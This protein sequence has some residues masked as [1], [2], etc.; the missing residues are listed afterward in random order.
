MRNQA[1]DVL[2]GVAIL[3]VLGFHYSYFRLWHQVGW[4]GVD[5]FFVLSGFLIS[6]LLFDEYAKTGTI[7]LRRFW[8][9]RGF[10]IYPPY[11]LLMF[12]TAVTFL[13]TK[14]HLPAGML[15]GLLFMQSYLPHVW[16]HT[17]SL[18]VE[19][20]FYF[21]LP[22]LLVLLA[23]RKQMR[24]VVWIFPVIALACLT[25]RYVDFKE[26]VS[27]VAIHSETHLR[28][29]ALFFGVFIRWWKTFERESFERAARMPLWIGAALM[30]PAFFFSP[31]G[32]FMDTLGL[33]LLYVA[34]GMVLVW[35]V[36]R[37]ASRNPGAR[38]L[39]WIGRYSY[40][41]YLW[42][43]PL[44]AFLYAGTIDFA[45]FAKGVVVSI[46][47]GCVMAKVV[48]IPG[49]KIRDKFFPAAS[50]RTAVILPEQPSLTPVAVSE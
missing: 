1:L 25:L 20:H 40:S 4:A 2:R 50:R 13:M 22:L 12:F 29:D 47:F 42:H 3:L 44:W 18:S 46:L 17:W 15:A 41:I 5:L 16:Q 10:K 9:R 36:E 37:P 6:G 34:F 48:E 27:A 14:G 8:I 26:G 7:D 45:F 28:I 38:L 39:A 49:L 33:T 19:E 23:K 31:V 35:A 21:V 32:E 24:S 30:A 11:Y 43:L